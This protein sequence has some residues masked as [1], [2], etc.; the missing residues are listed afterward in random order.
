MR[1]PTVALLAFAVPL[2]VSGVL[3][4]ERTHISNTDV[5]LVLAVLVI[6]VATTGG[7]PAA[8]AGSASAALWFDLWF[9]QPYDSL[10]ITAGRDLATTALLF[11]VGL[12]VAGGR[13]VALSKSREARLKAGEVARLQYVAGVL[14]SGR[15]PPEMVNVVEAELSD[16]LG[17]DSC[18]FEL[19]PFTTSLPHLESQRLVVLGEE[20][21][22]SLGPPNHAELRVC[23]GE[24]VLGR[25]VLVFGAGTLAEALGPSVVSV[26]VAIADQVGSVLGA[27]WSA[28]DW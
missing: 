24:H 13:E 19:F 16:L 21:G 18:H 28:D 6:A 2:G 3:L 10:R 15:R 9:T 25:F 23:R 27:A 5:A 1:R 22:A 11:V 14:A 12:L 17:L 20:L 7:W 26:A 8:I 4:Q